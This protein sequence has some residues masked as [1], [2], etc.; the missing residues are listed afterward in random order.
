[1]KFTTFLKVNKMALLA[2]VKAKN[3]P[4]A[5]RSGNSDLYIPVTEETKALI[6]KYAPFATTFI[7]QIEGGLWFDV[8]GAN[9]DYW[10]SLGKKK[11]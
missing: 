11:K 9:D 4:Y 2:E 10:K 5:T 6:K 7:N 1:M 8:F 3:I